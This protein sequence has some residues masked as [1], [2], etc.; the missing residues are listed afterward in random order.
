[1]DKKVTNKFI[2]A[3]EETS[4]KNTNDK[5]IKWYNYLAAFFAGL[6]LA[7]TIP[8]FVNGIS[9]R[10]FP[11]PFADPPAQGLPRLLQ[12][13]CGRYSIYCLVIYCFDLA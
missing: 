13:F 6:F 12:M 1:M 10:P 8:H 11:T 3:A 4:D 2:I 5:I 7:N 9:G